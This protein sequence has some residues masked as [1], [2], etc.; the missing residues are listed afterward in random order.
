MSGKVISCLLLYLPTLTA[1]RREMNDWSVCLRTSVNSMLS[2]MTLRQ[3][4][5]WGGTK[6]RRYNK[7]TLCA[8][9]LRQLHGFVKKHSKREPSYLET[10]VG[11][12]FSL[13]DG[14]QLKEV[15]TN[16]QL[17]APERLRRS[18]H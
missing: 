12:F 3:E 4:R 10:E 8:L 11:L 7:S 18:P 16:N 13:G 5:A 1:C 9:R 17:D 6:K 2:W 14:W 15:T